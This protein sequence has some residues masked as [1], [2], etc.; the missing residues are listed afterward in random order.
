MRRNKPRTVLSTSLAMNSANWL[1]SSYS[2]VKLL[3]NCTKRVMQ[4]TDK[5]LQA[6]IAAALWSS[7][8]ESTP[9]GGE[10]F[11]KNYSPEDL[12]PETIEMMK[13]D[14]NRF[15]AENA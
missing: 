2:V 12:A 7:N 15:R 14:C 3:L 13:A 1:V 5:L 11:D 9:A 8:D 4:N 10:P 6:Y